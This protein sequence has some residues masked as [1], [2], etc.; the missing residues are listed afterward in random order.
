MEV[1]A[2]YD[3]S[4]SAPKNQPDLVVHWERNWRRRGYKP[5]LITARHARRSKFYARCKN[6]PNALPLLAM[7]AVGG[8]WFTPF[9]SPEATRVTKA[10]LVRF[11][12]SRARK[13]RP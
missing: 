13:F 10:A 5:R 11:F 8:G 1:F 9:E 6:R 4:P 12:K 3:C 2:Y 7:H